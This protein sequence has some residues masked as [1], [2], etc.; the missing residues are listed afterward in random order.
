VTDDVVANGL[1]DFS[2]RRAAR[3]CGTTHKVLL[4]HFASVENLLAQSVEQLRARRIE[5][6]LA[7]AMSVP[8]DTLAER[9]RAVWPALI[10]RETD[11]LDQAMGLA[12]TDPQRYGQLAAGALDDYLPPLRA[13]CPPTWDEQRKDEVAAFVLATL[14]GLVLARRTSSTSFE[15]AHALAALDRALRREEAADK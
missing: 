10:G 5:G 3:A 11:A 1:A 2:L 9:V 7:A 12:M 6:G 8:G 15:P 14:R 13:L 4:Y